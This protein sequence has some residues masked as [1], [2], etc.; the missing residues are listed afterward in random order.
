MQIH[1]KRS[2]WLSMSHDAK[3][4]RKQ[5]RATCLDGRT[6]QQPRVGLKFMKSELKP[7]DLPGISGVESVFLYLEVKASHQ[8]IK[9]QK[10]IT[11]YEI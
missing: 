8:D 11:L 4:R 9:I 3:T 1:W 7:S 10:Y 5:R 6:P 2:R